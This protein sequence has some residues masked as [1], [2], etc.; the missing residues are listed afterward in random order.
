MIISSQFKAIE[1][2]NMQ[3]KSNSILYIVKDITSNA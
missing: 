1:G 3:K 2:T